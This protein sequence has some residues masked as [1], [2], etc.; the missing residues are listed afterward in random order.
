MIVVVDG[1]EYPFEGINSAPIGTVRNLKKITRGMLDP[2]EIIA[3]DGSVTLGPR[4]QGVTVRTFQEFAASLADGFDIL[5]LLGDESA[6]LHIQALIYLS[7]W[8]NGDKPTFDEC[9]VAFDA[10]ELRQDDDDEP[11]EVEAPKD[12]TA[13]AREMTS[14]A[15]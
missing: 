14:E 5:D 3:P 10:L 9:S 11:E 13:S 8:A 7:R 6:L 1:I 15:A 2:E 4:F 12:G